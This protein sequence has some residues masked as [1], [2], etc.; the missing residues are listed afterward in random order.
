MASILIVEDHEDTQDLLRKLIRSWG[1][2]TLSAASGEAGLALLATEIPD[3]IIVDG[4]MPGMNGAEFIRLLR[5]NEHI[6]HIPAV[7]Y[8]AV[9]DPVFLENAIAKGANECWVKGI[10][11]PAQMRQSIGKYLGGR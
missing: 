3:L 1:Y 2:Q 4:M 6:A 9:D 5:A 11:E 10:I 7:L 8:S